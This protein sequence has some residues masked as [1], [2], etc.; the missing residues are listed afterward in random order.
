[1]KVFQASCSKSE[2]PAA[3]PFIS[4][5]VTPMDESGNSKSGQLV[6]SPPRKHAGKARAIVAEAILG[7]DP[8]KA[9]Q[10]L[11]SIPTLSQFVREAYLPFAKNAK[12]SWR[13]DETVLRLHILPK[14]GTFRS[15]SGLGSKMQQSC[16]ASSARPAMRAAR[17]TGCWCSSGLCLILDGNGGCQVAVDNPTI[18]LKRRLTFAVN[19]FWQ[20]KK[21]NDCFRR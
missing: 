20:T 1:M 19:V 2:H 15:G 8:Q 5:I 4:V 11:R 10:E 17:P 12:R 13:T 14:L 21:R 7:N 6:C 3:K 9:R 16:F 18:G